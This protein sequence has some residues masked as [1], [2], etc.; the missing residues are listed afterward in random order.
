MKGRLV[1]NAD[2]LGLS[3]E[4][5]EGIL[6]GLAN[7]CISDTSMLIKAP[8]AQNAVEG[9]GSLGISHAG[10]HINLDEVLGWSP[11]GR[12][13]HPRRV[14][15]DLLETGGFSKECHAEARRQIEMF[16]STGLIPSH[17]DTHHHVHGFMSVFRIILAL[18]REYG[19]PAVRFSPKGYRLPTREDI[20]FDEGLYA[21]M[22]GELRER[23]LYS[24]DC[25]LEGAHRLE[26]TGPGDTELVVHP[27]RRGEP[28]R[29]AELD[30]LK[31]R[32]SDS[33][34][35]AR[36]IRVVSFRDLVGRS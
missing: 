6:W 3:R 8:H 30:S 11:G 18:A 12:E 10:I 31:G 7:G 27:S 34:L 36:G 24:C 5:N 29:S 2:D 13:V 32:D 17:I 23:G 1:I 9:L 28:W 33:R 22:Q 25:C 26:E 21:V 20:P 35:A 16:L 15:M 14:L 19:I 4:I